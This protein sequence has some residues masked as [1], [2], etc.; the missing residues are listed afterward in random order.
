MPKTHPAQNCAS[1][2]ENINM[3]KN[4]GYRRVIDS[5]I[6]IHELVLPPSL[7]LIIISALLLSCSHWF[8]SKSFEEDTLDL[9]H[10]RHFRRK[11]TVTIWNNWRRFFHSETFNLS[12]SFAMYP[13]DQKKHSLLTWHEY[14]THPSVFSLTDDA[15]D[16]FLPILCYGGFDVADIKGQ[17]IYLKI[18]SNLPFALLQ[19]SN[20]I[21]WNY[22]EDYKKAN[23]FNLLFLFSAYLNSFILYLSLVEISWFDETEF[24]I[25]REG[26]QMIWLSVPWPG[27]SLEVP[28]DIEMAGPTSDLGILGLQERSREIWC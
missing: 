19:S 11:E 3:C 10:F 28:G 22:F 12:Q 16:L 25:R 15:F 21:K 23:K 1:N 4:W 13:F 18:D 20:V 2:Y 24:L 26:I 9:H 5:L 7:H 8:C 14:F 27:C 17:V 6:K